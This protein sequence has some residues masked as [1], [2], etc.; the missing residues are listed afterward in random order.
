M[1]KTKRIRDE[2]EVI[3]H[4]QVSIVA[5]IEHAP[6]ACPKQ[7]H[8]GQPGQIHG[9]NVVGE[10]VIFSRQHGIPAEQSID[11][12]SVGS[13][14]AR[15]TKDRHT[16]PAANPERA[17]DPFSIDAPLR[18]RRGRPRGSGLVN[19]STHAVTIDTRGGNVGNP[20]W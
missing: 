8:A 12:Q 4:A 14:D 11:R 7:R 18:A 2:I 3:T 20:L 6:T 16:A 5:S 13:I 19:P 17:Q 1:R 10:Y 15:S 9:M